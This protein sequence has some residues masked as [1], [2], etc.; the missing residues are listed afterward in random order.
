MK[1]ETS[2]TLSQPATPGLSPTC[3]GVKVG[4]VEITPQLARQWLKHNIKNRKLK[5]DTVNSYA[6]DAKSGNW[7]LTHQGVAFNDRHELI[8]G[9]HRLEAIIRAGVAIK[10]MVTLGIPSAR[11]MDVVDQGVSRSIADILDLQHNLKHPRLIASSARIIATFCYTG[12]A[13]K[14]SIGQ[15]LEVYKLFGSEMEK[16]IERRGD[17]KC[18][19]GAHVTGAIA[20]AGMARS[21]DAEEFHR[22]LNSG[23]GLGAHNPILKVRNYL[24]STDAKAERAKGSGTV[25]LAQMVVGAI[26]RFLDDKDTVSDEQALEYFCLLQKDRVAKVKALFELPTYFRGPNPDAD[27]AAPTA[28]EAEWRKIREE[29]EVKIQD[30]NDTE[31]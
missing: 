6:R 18:L 15:V 13:R 28:K 19:W 24:I 10:M 1:P 25:P 12:R 27:M 2:S 8:D 31:R 22:K 21:T 4:F 16:A 14:L 3:G 11:S 26:K 23:A 7:L 17:L 20:F 9:Q 5:E 29:M 30:G